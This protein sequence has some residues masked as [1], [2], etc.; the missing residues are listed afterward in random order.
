M[1]MD[2]DIKA[3]L[4][5]PNEP[6]E[7]A[8]ELI[9]ATY[10]LF[11]DEIRDEPM[12]EFWDEAIAAVRG[13]DHDAAGAALDAIENVVEQARARLRSVEDGT[14]WRKPEKD[15]QLRHDVEQPKEGARWGQRR[16]P[17]SFS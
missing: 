4:D 3:I 16:K 11:G 10:L 12:K 9:D 13:A 6:F 7:T 8:D 17:R 5:D 2:S 15:E 1:G 14:A